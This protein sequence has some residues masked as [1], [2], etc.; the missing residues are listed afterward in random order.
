MTPPDIL[1]KTSAW[2]PVVYQSRRPKQVFQAEHE[3]FLTLTQ[4]IY[5]FIYLFTFWP[6]AKKPT[7]TSLTSTEYRKLN[8]KKSKVSPRFLEMYIYPGDQVASH[9]S[10]TAVGQA[11]G[12]PEWIHH[13]SSP[14]G[15]FFNSHNTKKLNGTF[16]HPLFFP[17]ERHTRH[18]ESI[19]THNP[20]LKI[21][22][23]KYVSD[24]L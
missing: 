23:P 7:S 19:Q 24:K 10:W 8:L 14:C 15:S 21:T 20:V 2:F 22:T 3:H 17:L 1:K 6:K 4:M 5:L 18:Q 16:L 12:P 11:P 9:P 13:V